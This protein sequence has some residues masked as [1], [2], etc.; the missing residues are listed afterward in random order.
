[1]TDSLP[2]LYQALLAAVNTD[3][4]DALQLAIE[5]VDNS[6]A[7]LC[8]SQLRDPE[9]SATI[10]HHAMLNK[11]EK[12]TAYM[13]I[14][15]ST[16]LLQQEFDV[17]V[18]GLPSKKT[19]LHLLTENGD[20][21]LIKTMMDRL[22]N[23]KE[24]RIIFLKKTVLLV[25]KGQR[26]HHMCA[27]D[28]AAL[29]GNSAIVELFVNLGIKPDITNNRNDTPMLWAVRGNHLET[30]RQLIK[31]GADPNIENDKGSTPLHWAV[32]YGY[33]DLLPVLIDEG[34]ANVHHQRKQGLMSTL[35]LASAM[36][37][38]DI[39]RILIEHGVE[40]TTRISGGEQALHH[41]AA[42]GHCSIISI[43]IEMGANVNGFDDFE[44]TPL[45]HAARS[46]E[47][48]AII[49]L[50]NFGANMDCRNKLGKTMWDYA[51][52]HDNHNMLKDI[53]DVYRRV[54]NMPQSN[55]DFPDGKKSPLHI[56]AEK[57]DVAKIKL[58]L[59]KGAKPQ[60]KDENGN[61][62]FHLAAKQNHLDILK[63]FIDEVNPN[64][65]NND[66]DTAMHLACQNG[67]L[68]TITTLMK[69]SNMQKRNNL[70][71]T[72][73]HV[74]AKSH[75]TRAEVVAYLI[76]AVLKSSSWSLVDAADVN[77]NTALHLA[78]MTGRKEIIPSLKHLNPTLLNQEGE[79][80]LH[81]AAKGSHPDVLQT[82]LEVFNVYSKA[83]KIDQQNTQGE[84]LLHICAEQGDAQMVEILV[85]QGADLALKDTDGNSVLHAL[86]LKTITDPNNRYVLLNVFQKIVKVAPIWWCIKQRLNIPDTFSE[87]YSAYRRK[88]VFHMVSDI[89]NDIGLNVICYSTK[90]GAKEFLE[91]LVNLPGIFRRRKR[92]YYDFDV[93]HLIPET[94]QKPP[95][96]DNKDKG[97]HG[98]GNSH[99][100]G[101]GHGHSHGDGHGC[102]SSSLDFV[103]KLKDE[104]LAA[105]I[106][107]MT[108]FRHLVTSYWKAYQWIYGLL[109]TIHIIFMSTFS[110]FSIPILTKSLDLVNGT[111]VE[112]HAYPGIFFVSW[113]ILILLFNI[114]Y[115][116]ADVLHHAKHRRE[117][118]GVSFCNDMLRTLLDVP[119]ILAD[120]FM[121]SLSH[122]ASLTFSTLIILWFVLHMVSSHDVVYVLSGALIIGW[123]F[124]ISF[125]KGFQ[126][127]HSFSI[128]LKYIILRDIVRFLFIYLLV[129]LGFT[130]GLHALFQMVPSL[131]ESHQSTFDT[132]F[133]T[134]NLMIGMGEIFHDEFDEDHKNAGRSG[135]FT[136]VVYLFYVVLST[137]ILLNILIAMM[138]DTYNRIM[139]Q[140]GT[141]W[142]ISSVRVAVQL[143]HSLS[144]IPRFFRA[145]G[146]IRNRVEYD[147]ESER[148]TLK[149][150]TEEIEETLDKELDEMQRLMYKL[151]SNI[152]NL[153]GGYD[154]MNKK[155]DE[156]SEEVSRSSKLKSTGAMTTKR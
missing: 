74:A 125:T 111:S 143:E 116:V 108:P 57:G 121:G 83:F 15:E 97:S 27:L 72:V 81:A 146:I 91:K 60:C 123:M 56:A 149:I 109:M 61:T 99:G 98:H 75:K 140:E 9:T 153:Q 6:A 79:S 59:K 129:L 118:K 8:D 85:K 151:E 134:F 102:S 68:E 124:T 51:I 113:P 95:G 120:F 49:T 145:I 38:E 92:T 89:K 115:I 65:K 156:L 58:I 150:S 70:H 154:D 43:L 62:Y 69:N 130:F 16:E 26:P 110:T 96:E 14:N 3:D 19:C 119:Y 103:V 105:Q 31:L 142:R 101:H 148:Y 53:I 24:E 71:E 12:T 11:K 106:L 36:G 44:N 117:T 133:L 22:D 17:D 144:F 35:V 28:I 100:H 86:A 136:K 147:E 20:Y 138:S 5:S 34:K 112:P 54:K 37:Y 32:R 21:D 132:L 104:V 25:I 87:L 1:M 84:S 141:T 10:L 13:V 155:L 2:S 7:S 67:N 128:M 66:G 73:L 4:L 82:L 55:L 126:T 94:T 90:L 77:G 139:S 23:K 48:N 122:I 76:D 46:R 33:A 78:A 93:T 107:D 50:V 137:I 131:S 80:P 114:C 135:T 30:V 18:G 40:A 63:T 127:V 29:N 39:V 64:K 47:T 88:A 41:A 45:L 152:D 42:N 52:D